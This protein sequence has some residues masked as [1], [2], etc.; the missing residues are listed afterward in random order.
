LILSGRTYLIK[1][2][3]KP[4]RAPRKPIESFVPWCFGGYLFDI[5]S[6][7]AIAAHDAS[8]VKSRIPA[9]RAA[10][11]GFVFASKAFPPLLHH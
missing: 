9:A 7:R 10:G 5:S 2:N 4:P 3:P 11:R 6:T 8:D 1:G